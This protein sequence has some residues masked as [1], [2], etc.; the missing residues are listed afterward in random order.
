MG[1]VQ[2]G[3]VDVERLCALLGVSVA[4]IRRD[5]NQLASDGSIVRTYGG[6]AFV[7]HNRH[8]HTL[9]ERMQ[10]HSAQKSAIARLA[11]SKI[12]DGETIILDAGTTTAALARE[13]RGRADLH[14]I[15]NN[16][17]AFAILAHDPA[18]RITLLGG[19]LRPLSMGTLGPL[20][21]MALARISA[22]KVFLGA[23]GIVA[24]R[25]LCE[26]TPEQACLK[27]KMM[28]QADTI[29]VLADA[30]KLGFPVQQNWTPLTRPWTLITDVDASVSARAAFEKL[31][32]VTVLTAPPGTTP[33]KSKQEPDALRPTLR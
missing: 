24:S 26:A 8:E 27:E 29:F 25:G 21:D 28:A 6:A 14:V 16:V 5:L 31:P 32:G 12:E 33:L 23:D 19:A 15:T 10:I 18:I 22:D 1:L 11:A 4:T 7:R 3:P 20:T 30:S 2:D 13:L 17:E 9:N